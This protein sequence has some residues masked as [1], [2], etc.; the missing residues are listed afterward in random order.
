MSVLQSSAN[1]TPRHFF[2]LECFLEGVNAEYSTAAD[3][4]NPSFIV[5]HSFCSFLYFLDAVV[6]F[7]NP[8]GQHGPVPAVCYLNLFLSGYESFGSAFGIPV[9]LPEQHGEL[10]SLRFGH[11]P[12]QKRRLGHCN[13]SSH[14][15]CIRD[16][17]DPPLHTHLPLPQ[18]DRGKYRSKNWI[19]KDMF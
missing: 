12:V 6:S 14:W 19:F 1:V 17:A 18:G 9:G 5:L 16:T 8:Y 2:S 10:H 13:G 4:I 15:L 3:D 7:R 11:L